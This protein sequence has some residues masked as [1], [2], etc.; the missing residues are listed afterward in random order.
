[1]PEQQV[2]ESV[3]RADRWSKVLA[4]FFA[5]GVYLAA[6]QLTGDI[7]FSM[8][9]AAF[10]GIGLRIYIPYHASITVSDPD[11]EPIQAYEGTGNYHQGAVGA[12]VTLASLLALVVMLIEPNSTPA[13]AA[14]GGAGVVLFLLLKRFLPS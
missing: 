4:L 1:M 8:I 2:D 9:V 7:Q 12:A 6:S 13:L 3:I 10:A 14:G 11:H 5:A